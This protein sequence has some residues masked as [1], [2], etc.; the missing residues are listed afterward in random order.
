MNPIGHADLSRD[1]LAI[2][3][4]HAFDWPDYER[5]IAIA[6][7]DRG[8]LIVWSPDWERHRAQ[9][10][11]KIASQRILAHYVLDGVEDSFTVFLSRKIA[12]SLDRMMLHL[13]NEPSAQRHRKHQLAWLR[14]RPHVAP[15]P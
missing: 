13:F 5:E 9:G 12:D 11:V 6:P 15:P 3:H 2:D 7:N 1:K 14:L 4:L 10:G 8:E